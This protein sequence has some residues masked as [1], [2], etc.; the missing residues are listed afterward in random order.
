LNQG[1]VKTIGVSNFSIKTL[2][3]LLPHCAVL[4][5]LNQVE[6]HPC[7]PQTQLKAYCEDKGILLAAYSPFG[8]LAHPPTSHIVAD[9]RAGRSTTFMEDATIIGL[10]DKLEVSAAQVVIS[11]AVNCCLS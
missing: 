9:M 5:A 6:L 8:V 7:L 11:W 2:E 10:A 3:E 4:P 1:K